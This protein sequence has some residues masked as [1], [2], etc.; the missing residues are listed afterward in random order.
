MSI[1]ELYVLR[2]ET[3]SHL[4]EVADLPVVDGSDSCDHCQTPI[5]GA[6]T[7][8]VGYVLSLT[9]DELGDEHYWY[10]CLTCAA[11]VIAPLHD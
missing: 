9:E 10:T 7:R 6:D 8:F 11:P 4:A 1:L 5:G 2:T 3:D